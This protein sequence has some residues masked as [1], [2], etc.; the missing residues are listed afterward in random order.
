MDN[1]S[2]IEYIKIPPGSS[3]TL[4]GVRLNPEIPLPVLRSGND[5]TS[6]VELSAIK[7]GIIYALS[8][9][10]SDSK[11]FAH[12]YLD[13]YKSII[14]GEENAVLNLLT[15]AKVRIEKKDYDNAET[16]LKAISILMPN[17][18][19]FILLSA[20][21]AYKAAEAQKTNIEDYEAY[22][23]LVFETLKAARA[24]FP[25][26]SDIAYELA[27][28]HF[29]EGN[30]VSAAEYLDEFIA[31]YKTEDAR[32]KNAKK[33]RNKVAEAMEKEDEYAEVYDL[34]MTDRFD[35]GIKKALA[36]YEKY[37]KEYQY[38]L[39]YGWALRVSSK[40]EEA[41]NVLL[42]CLKSDNTDALFYNE[43]AMSE[44]EVGSKELAKVY[45]KTA[46]DLDRD[47]PSYSSNLVLMNLYTSDYE[48][49]EKSLY[50]LIETDD[51]DPMIDSLIKE[52]N[53]SAPYKFVYPN[54]DKDEHECD[55]HDK[56][57]IQSDEHHHSDHT[58]CDCH[59]HDLR[60]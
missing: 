27:S 35:E 17:E 10:A 23:N 40:F 44:W 24:M 8:H 56:E 28:F 36:L 6:D 45:M 31:S 1:K 25:Q 29:R 32:L 41:R 37:N 53:A 51:K 34:I 46:E 48:N 22:D 12:K 33:M 59:K 26:S 9:Y 30:F 47:N 7:T 60:E 14:L 42:S 57:H 16:L 58:H 49:A 11:G 52:F 15:A 2:Y 21:Y 43:L 18:E 13:Y 5:N 3:V 19:T 4:G 55:C 50:N 54:R 38:A 20:V 39:L